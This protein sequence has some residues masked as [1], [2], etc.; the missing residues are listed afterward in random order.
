MLGQITPPELWV[1]DNLHPPIFKTEHSA[2]LNYG[3]GVFFKAVDGI[4]EMSKMSNHKLNKTPC[5]S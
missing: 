4:G 5:F 2:P 1:F 3:E